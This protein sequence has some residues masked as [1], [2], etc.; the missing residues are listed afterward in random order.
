MKKRVAAEDC[1]RCGWI[2]DGFPRTER[3]AKLMQV[4]PSA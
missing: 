4:R 1:Q 3:Q 2:L